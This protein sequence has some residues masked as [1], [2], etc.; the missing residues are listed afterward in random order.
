MSSLI[1]PQVYRPD[2]DGLRAF[3]VVS[4]VV[5]HAFPDM[6]KG[7]FIGVDVFFVISGYLIGG[8]LLRDLRDGRFSFWDFYARRILRIFPALIVVLT[9]VLIFGWFALW[10]N[11]YSSLGKHAV[12]GTLF[13]S[14]LLSWME[15]SYF[16]TSVRYTPLLHL[17]SL[18]IEEQFYIFFP[19]LI[20]L[21]FK[22]RIL[23]SFVIIFLGL[24]S[25][26]DNLYLF[27]IDARADFY[28][29]FARLWELLA[30]AGLAS[31]SQMHSDMTVRHEWNTCWFRFLRKSSP[32]SDGRGLDLPLAL[33]GSCFLCAGLLLARSDKPWP[34]WGGVMPVVG[35]L[36]LIAAGPANPINRLVLSNPV[37]VF[38]GKISYPLY[39]WHWPLLS[40]FF[41]IGGT[42]NASTLTLRTGLIFL[43]FF[44]ATLTYV[45][46][47]RPLRFGLGARSA[48]LAA[49]IFVMMIVGVAGLSIYYSEGLPNRKAINLSMQQFEALKYPPGVDNEG[50]QYA[51]I[52]A[53]D[54]TYCRYMHTGA[55]ET[56]AVV[57]DSHAMVAFP[58]IAAL[59]EELG[60]NT[61]LL[62]WLV[63][64]G[65]EHLRGAPDWVWRKD[66]PKEIEKVLRI[67]AEKQDIRK[68]FIISV[69]MR[70]IQGGKKTDRW[71]ARAAG[72]STY[73][74]DLQV[75]VDY[76]ND[77]G[78]L[79]Y[80]VSENPEY[81]DDT[82]LYIMRPFR[83]HR[84]FK[85]AKV[86]SHGAV[87][88]FQA[89]YLALL[90]EI[91]G[92]TIIDTI[93][94]FCASG[95]CAGFTASGMPLY[96]DDNHLTEVGNLLL[97]DQALRP[98]LAGSG[99]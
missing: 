97:R 13:I 79:V 84:S 33:V 77:H 95:H 36:A 45:M 54:L 10:P 49:L 69:G 1:K 74:Q 98:Y 19:F 92:A 17:W 42:V 80:I 20:W 15:S 75:Y 56:I 66:R 26:L 61:L 65:T 3:A 93:N 72:V 85:T 12:S 58:S 40:F 6:L 25:F 87:R 27:R 63:P 83:S 48:K 53:G 21:S 62:G 14:N 99:K 28:S 76:L 47:E 35:T 52:Q 91:R 96:H 68:V 37:A 29:P 32:T 67:V 38:V 82:K 8:I 60:Y 59:G 30:G 57:G 70:V 89:P 39:L 50:L 55:T 18:G 24:L 16:D 78:K 51:D 44:L 2:I 4:V 23:P 88:E 34:G 46:V 86:L 73:K 7:G 11:E 43:S 90:Q 81:P 41:I 22:N 31:L 71:T 9:A 5:F 94:V 64:G